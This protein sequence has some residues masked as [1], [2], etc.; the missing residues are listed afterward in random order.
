MIDRSEEWILETLYYANKSDVDTYRLFLTLRRYIYDVRDFTGMIEQINPKVMRIK[1]NTDLADDCFYSVSMF[2]KHINSRSKRRGAPDARF[3]SKVG[4][5]AFNN[6]GY[7]G[8]AKNW[9]F[10]VAYVQEHMCI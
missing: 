2:S 9:K 6:I 8:I 3:Y 5:G 10:W 7:P 4:K 1:P